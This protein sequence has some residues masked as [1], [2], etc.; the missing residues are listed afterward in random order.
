MEAEELFDMLRGKGEDVDLAEVWTALRGDAAPLACPKE[1]ARCP[2]AEVFAALIEAGELSVEKVNRAKGAMVAFN[3]VDKSRDGTI[4]KEEFLALFRKLKLSE[5]ED[6]L[7]ELWDGFD[8][9]GNGDL[10][11]AEFISAMAIVEGHHQGTTAKELKIMNA[12]SFKLNVEDIAAMP[13]FLVESD[14]SELD[15]EKRIKSLSVMERIAYEMLKLLYTRRKTRK[16]AVASPLRLGSECRIGEK[17]GDS[18]RQVDSHAVSLQPGSRSGSA[19]YGAEVGDDKLGSQDETDVRDRGAS[20]DDVQIDIT[21]KVSTDKYFA[22]DNERETVK[23]LRFWAIFGVS[24][25]GALSATVCAFAEYIADWKFGEPDMNSEAAKEMNFWYYWIIVIVPLLICSTIEVAYMYY[26]LLRTALLMADT[27]GL[28]LYPADPQ[29]TFVASALTRGALELPHPITPIL[30]VDPYFST[31]PFTKNLIKLAYMSKTGVTNFLLRIFFKR[32]VFRS[33]LRGA[34][35]FVAIPV[36]AFMNFVIAFRTSKDIFAAVQGVKC[37][38]GV[39]EDL[40]ARF[41]GEYPDKANFSPQL[42]ACLFRVA[43]LVIVSKQQVHPNHEIL[44]KYMRSRLAN[45]KCPIAEE[46]FED[47]QWE[48]VKACTDAMQ[49]LAEPEKKLCMKVMALAVC[50]DGFALP[51]TWHLYQTVSKDSKLGFTSILGLRGAEKAFA[52][53]ELTAENFDMIPHLV[54]LESS[55]SLADSAEIF[56]GYLVSFFAIF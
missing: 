40:L 30:G 26:C 3:N 39:F 27:V 8:A 47:K 5:D 42:R 34:V 48:D 2:S 23:R 41:K 25:A 20:V 18:R 53:F 51:K 31:N 44:L 11:F 35:P 38:P 28:K 21:K 19:V 54:S 33:V 49:T 16:D 52:R 24:M 29:R 37:G 45:A 10:S 56:V 6:E 12:R 13:T 7:V 43:A 22:T 14:V 4:D 15:S 17:R 1:L 32:V 46:G 36:C 9:D 55:M 50:L